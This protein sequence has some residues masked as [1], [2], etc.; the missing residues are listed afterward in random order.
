[1]KKTIN[2]TL[3]DGTK[4]INHASIT[5]EDGII[6]SIEE[7]N[8][9]KSDYFV[10]P[11]LIDA[12][13]HMTNLDDVNQMLNYGIN[14]TF[15]VC[16]S[17]TLIEASKDLNIIS[18]MN[19]AMGIVLNPKKFVDDAVQNGAKYI[20]VLLFNPLSIGAKALKGIVDEA[21]K[22]N[23]K[24]AVHATEITTY[25]QAVD[26]NADIL[27]H[28]PMKD[29][30]TDE[31]ASLIASK[32]IAVT[33]T[34]VMMKAFA[35]S[36]KNGYTQEHFKNAINQVKTL[37][38]NGV[39]ILVGTDANIGSFAPLVTY[40]DSVYDEIHFLLEAKIPLIEVLKGAT[41]KI[42]DC[43]NMDLGKIEIGKPCNY[44]VFKILDN[45]IEIDSQ[46][47]EEIWI[48]GRNRKF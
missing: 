15:D 40:G 17:S 21:H 33:P 12:H 2:C 11:C 22:R 23:L 47:L 43:F 5:I 38:K 44:L 24:V 28:L 13:T 34:L 3:F 4:L 42:G 37:Y 27:L 16:A 35:D 32:N 10:M 1:M 26:A 19:M 9:V 8:E 6:T 25:K 36:G 31:F 30:L 7:N 46:Y 20:K 48:N 39:Q 14:T 41:S 29:N 18:S 45:H